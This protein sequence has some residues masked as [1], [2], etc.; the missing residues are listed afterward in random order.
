[1]STCLYKIH[2]LN[3][4]GNRRSEPGMEFASFEPDIPSRN[5]GH[6]YVYIYI[7]YLLLAILSSTKIRIET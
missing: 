3:E 1:V 4:A 2:I 6:V 7:T 5:L